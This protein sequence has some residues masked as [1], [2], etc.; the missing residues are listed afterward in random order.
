M[1][2]PLIGRLNQGSDKNLVLVRYFGQSLKNESH[3]VL[4]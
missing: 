3:D 1:K 4:N 2:I